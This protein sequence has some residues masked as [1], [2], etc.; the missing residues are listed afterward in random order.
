MLKNANTQ[1]FITD[2][3]G[4]RHRNE[5]KGDCRGILLSFITRSIDELRNETTKS[6][7]KEKKAKSIFILTKSEEQQKKWRRKLHLSKHIKSDARPSFP[8][9]VVG[10]G[11]RRSCVKGGKMLS[12]Q[13]IRFKKSFRPRL[14]TLCIFNRYHRRRWINYWLKQGWSSQAAAEKLFA[15]LVQSGAGGVKQKSLCVPGCFLC[16]D[17]PIRWYNKYLNSVFTALNKRPCWE[18]R[19]KRYWV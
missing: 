11:E 19:K 16:V 9:S 5:K 17:S 1:V 7:A 8:T 15:S 14:L 18:Y 12:I 2:D 4:R 6:I 3:R 10:G 13:K